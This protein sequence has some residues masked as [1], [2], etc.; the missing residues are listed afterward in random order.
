MVGD[1]SANL[2]QGGSPSSAAA[3]VV[4]ELGYIAVSSR[5][6]LETQVLYEVYFSVGY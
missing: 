1:W 5:E 2:S 3:G 6:R 4:W